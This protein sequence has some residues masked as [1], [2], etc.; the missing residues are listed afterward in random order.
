MFINCRFTAPSRSNISEKISDL[1][2]ALN[3]TGYVTCNKVFK[4]TVYENKVVDELSDA[5]ADT[6]ASL[7]IIFMSYT[8]PLQEH[9]VINPA[10]Y[11]ASIYEIT[12]RTVYAFTVNIEI[13]ESELG[14]LILLCKKIVDNSNILEKCKITVDK[15]DSDSLHLLEGVEISI[16]EVN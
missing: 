14:N 7:A 9:R 3:A 16:K 15:N 2:K 4:G 11:G 10:L 6:M 1:Q 12:G 8:S 13:E 5:Y